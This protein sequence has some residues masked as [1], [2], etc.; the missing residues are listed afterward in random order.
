MDRADAAGD[1]ALGDAGFDV[2]YEALELGWRGE[3]NGGGRLAENGGDL[4][5]ASRSTRVDRT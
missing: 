4:A 5:C 1:R 3:P 2:E